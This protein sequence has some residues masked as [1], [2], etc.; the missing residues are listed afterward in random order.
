MRSRVL[1]A[2]TVVDTGKASFRH[3]L[4]VY[5][6]GGLLS[7]CQKTRGKTSTGFSH[8]DKGGGGD[9]EGE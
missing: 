7:L 2:E 5:V 1:S 9:G 4:V 8:S 3:S 6:G